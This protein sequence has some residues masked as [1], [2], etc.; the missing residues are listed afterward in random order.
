MKIRRTLTAGLAAT[1][2]AAGLTTAT[3]LAPASGP[4]SALGPQS[5]HAADDPVPQVQVFEENGVN[6][7]A[8]ANAI[9]QIR[10]GDRG[11]FVQEAVTAAFDNDEGD[12]NVVLMNLSQ[13]YDKFGLEGTHLYANVTWG[14]IRYGL[15]IVDAGTFKNTGDGGY[16]NWG[17][18]GWYDRPDDGTVVFKRP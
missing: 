18:Q 9:N 3:T 2:I 11:Q 16:I 17:F 6:G 12:Y 15:W 13:G 4:T 14:S 1:A 10:T 8:V 7:P 5:A